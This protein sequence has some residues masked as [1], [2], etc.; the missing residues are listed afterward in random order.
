[1]VM[2]WSIAHGEQPLPG[3]I[4]WISS[5][6]FRGDV[7]IWTEN[8]KLPS[9]ELIS[10]WTLTGATR[11][12]FD[13][14]TVIP[15]NATYYVVANVAQFKLR[16]TGPAGGQKL[17]IQGNYDGQLD[18]AFG[19]LTL[20][21]SSNATIA[22]TNYGTL[23]DPGDYNADNQVDGADFLA[24]QRTLGLPAAPAGSGGRRKW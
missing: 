22:S 19:Q 2:R 3:F 1:M 20:K 24:W 17:L 6:L 4:G 21:D 7:F 12:T 11:H 10:G 23:S 9:G 16:T 5:S 14:G 8:F 15:A 18:N 13:G